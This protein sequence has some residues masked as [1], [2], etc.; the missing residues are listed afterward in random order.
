MSNELM[1]QELCDDELELVAGGHTYINV[2]NNVNVN[3]TTN[4][5]DIVYAPVYIHGNV[6]NSSIDNGNTYLQH[7]RIYTRNH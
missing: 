4:Y 6:T 3:V 1:M 5:Y 2:T 7:S